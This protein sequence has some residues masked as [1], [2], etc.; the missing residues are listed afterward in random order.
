MNK[1]HIKFTFTNCKDGKILVDIKQSKNLSTAHLSAIAEY[2][3]KVFTKLK[4]A[5]LVDEIKDGKNKRK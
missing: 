1:E 3:D 5:G 4:E 2:L